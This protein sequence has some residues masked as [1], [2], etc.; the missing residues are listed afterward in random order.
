MTKLSYVGGMA[1]VT[2]LATSAVSFAKDE[3]PAAAPAEK[4]AA[5]A[6]PAAQPA[7]TPAAKPAEAAKPAAGAPAPKMEPA[8]PAPPAGEAAKPA[9]PPKMEPPKP[10]PE[11]DAAFKVISGTWKCTGTAS[12]PDG[13]SMPIDYTMSFKLDLDKFWIVGTMASK[14]TK[15]N[16]VAYKFTSYSTYD[17]AAKKWTRVMMDNMGG[18]EQGTSTGMANNVMAWEGK[19]NGM[20]MTYQSKHTEEVKGPK[21]THMVGTMSMDG[22]NWMPMYEATCKK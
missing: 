8:K 4:K 15:A 19:G 17:A 20:G 9:A 18:W 6:A 12:G 3:K 22:K 7:G 1:V 14:K 5:A 2:L 10:A 13:A 16:P 11:I 21:E